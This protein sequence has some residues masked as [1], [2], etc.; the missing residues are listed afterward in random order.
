MF[1]LFFFLPLSADFSFFFVTERADMPSRIFNDIYARTSKNL[2]F[3]ALHCGAT[4]AQKIS[5]SIRRQPS[6]STQQRNKM[7][8]SNDGEHINQLRPHR[9]SLTWSADNEINA[10]IQPHGFGSFANHLKSCEWNNNIILKRSLAWEFVCNIFYT[11]NYHTGNNLL[12]Q[13]R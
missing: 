13:S 11:L 4:N 6:S 12:D 10:H 1:S 5:M 8:D 7:Q 3:I 9:E 2:F